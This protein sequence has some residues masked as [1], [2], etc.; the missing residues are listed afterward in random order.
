MI[1]RHARTVA[2]CLSSG[3]LALPACG[4]VV[5]TCLDEA[6][7]ESS[8]PSV[9]LPD[10]GSNPVICGEPGDHAGNDETVAALAGCEVYR[11]S[12]VLGWPATDLSPLGS[13]R[14]IDGSLSTPGFGHELETLDGLEQLQS[15]GEFSFYHD[16][17]RGMSGVPNLREVAGF[18]QLYG[19]PNLTD[20]DG[21]ENLQST[22][23]FNVFFNPSLVD[24]D[25]LSDLRHVDGDLYIDANPELTSIGGLMALEHVTGDLYIRENPKVPTCQIDA[26]LARVTVDGEVHLESE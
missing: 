7:T 11:G 21:L 17:L 16:G 19:L 24:I 13:L 22:G 15:V 25:G 23:T 26:L 3:L 9:P 5:D 6:S 1:A 20:L 4:P 14:I 2:F 10:L 8:E 18:F 12:L